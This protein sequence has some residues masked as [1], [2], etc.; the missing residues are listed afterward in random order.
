MHSAFSGNGWPSVEFEKIA[1]TLRQRSSLGQIQGG[2]ATI[3]CLSIPAFALFF[4]EDE[5]VE[6]YNK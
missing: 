5:I 6:K 2:E 3:D 1:N 4:D